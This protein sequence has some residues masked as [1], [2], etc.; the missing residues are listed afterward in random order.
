MI[1]AFDRTELEMTLPHEDERFVEHTA[2]SVLNRLVLV[3]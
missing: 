1:I 2:R 3:C